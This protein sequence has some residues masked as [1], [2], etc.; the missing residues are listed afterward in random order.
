MTI[1]TNGQHPPAEGAADDPADP[2][3]PDAASSPLAAL[4]EHPVNVHLFRGYGPLVV[5]VILFVLMVV[6]APTVAPE[7]VVERPLDAPT[8]TTVP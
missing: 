1:T 7:H 5:G 8:E 6:L 3:A 4:R 2:P